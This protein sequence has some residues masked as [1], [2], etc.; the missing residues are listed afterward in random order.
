MSEFSRE[1][2]LNIIETDHVQCGEASALARMALAAMD[3]EPVAWRVRFK[4]EGQPGSNFNK[5]FENRKSMDDVVSLHELDGFNID[6]TPLYRHAQPAPEY[7]ETLPC[8]VLLEPGMR[9]GKGVKT[10]LVLDAIQ[11]R[12]E[13]YAELE[14]MTQEERAEYD[15]N[16]EAFKAM[17]PQPVPVAYSDFE[18]FWSSYI[19][20]LAQDDELKGFAWDTWCAAMLQAGK[21]SAHVVDRPVAWHHTAKSKEENHSNCCFSYSPSHDFGPRYEKPQSQPHYLPERLDYDRALHFLSTEPRQVTPET[22]IGGNSTVIPDGS[23]DMLRRWLAFGRGMQNAGCQLPHNLIVESEA[24]LAAA[25]HDT[26]ALNPV[27]SVVTVPGKWIPVS[28][29][30]PE[31]GDWLVTDG[32]DFDVQLFN[33][34][35]FIPGFVWEDKITHWMPLPAVPQEVR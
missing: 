6:V 27:Q 21:S 7:P 1:T 17:L 24:M 23:A 12:A 30:M 25:Q 35:Q 10:R 16:I 20:P 28:E 31:L 2:L 14:A 33:G 15:A 3:S 8:P 5:F 22:V 9:F 4:L 34:E 26:P 29:R 18:S 32:C 11:R 19:H 13:Q